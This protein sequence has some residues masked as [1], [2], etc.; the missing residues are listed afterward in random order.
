MTSTIH[1]Y[2]NLYKTIHSETA[3]DMPIKLYV[4]K[5]CELILP[6]YFIQK[7]RKCAKIDQ[8]PKKSLTDILVKSSALVLSNIDFEF[9]KIF[10]EIFC[11]SCSFLFFHETIEIFFR[12]K[13]DKISGFNSVLLKMGGMWSWINKHRFEERKT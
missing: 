3:T 11:S 7:M 12:F 6:L 1:T 4:T 5:I 8:W 13:T 9:C 2:T 10:F